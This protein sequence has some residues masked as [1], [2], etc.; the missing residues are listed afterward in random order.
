MRELPKF[1]DTF[2]PILKVL[3]DGKIIHYNE[4]KKRVRDTYYSDLPEELLALKT[5]SGDQLILNRIGWGKAYLKQ[6]GYVSI[7]SRAMVQITQN[8]QEALERGILSLKEVKRQP[9][10]VA[11][12][13]AKKSNK[14]K[15]II[16]DEASPQDMIDFGVQSIEDDV[17]ADIL[18]KLK[19]TDPY[20]FE[21]VVLELFDKMGYGE[22]IVTAKSG[23]GG[24]DGVINQ[25]VLGLEKIYVQ[26]KR[27]ANG[28]VREPAIR[29]FIG[30]LSADTEKG[31]FVTTSFF[32]PKAIL[33]AKEARHRI[34]LIDGIQLSEY[35]YKYGIGV[36][37][38]STYAVKGV[39]EDYFV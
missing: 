26:A 14:Q 25:D 27:Y 8:G 23:D 6:A 35:M 36:Q 2:I 37:V 21:K 12:E 16:N 9:E 31:I 11:H 4:L 20:Y 1:Y 29:N 13:L 18:E 5:K 28:A 7:P 38:E 10:Y 22:S 39:D 15:E 32:E 30:A 33:K 24:I 17:K 19:T 34:I 3:A